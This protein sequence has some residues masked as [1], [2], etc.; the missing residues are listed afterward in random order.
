MCDRR[1][2]RVRSS[3]KFNIGGYRWLVEAQDENVVF[4]S[5]GYR[6]FTCSKPENA[7]RFEMYHIPFQ[8]GMWITLGC[9]M[10]TLAFCYVVWEKTVYPAGPADVGR[11]VLVLLSSLIEDCHPTA[12]AASKKTAFRLPFGLWF[13][14]STVFS[15]G[16]IG[17]VINFLN[18]PPEPKPYNEWKS[19]P[20]LTI[21]EEGQNGTHRMNWFR[22]FSE[23][24]GTYYQF[25]DMV[26]ALRE[27]STNLNPP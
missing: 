10:S 8:W 7:L 20:G 1:E 4:G 16:Y 23:M 22:R 25:G 5:F 27:R 3:L 9:A 6:F 18:V 15:A 2:I 17:V 12:S 13:L 11:V 19:L 14:L 26:R 24:R 21:G